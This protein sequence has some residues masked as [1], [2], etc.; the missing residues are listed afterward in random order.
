MGKSN[1][2][3]SKIKSEC[4]KAG[5][6]YS[7]PAPDFIGD[8]SPQNL[9]KPHIGTC[10]AICMLCGQPCNIYFSIRKTWKRNPSTKIKPS[11]K[12]YKRIK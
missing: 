4:C 8:S 2:K 5:V 7:E 1:K 11:K 3:K 12:I 10:Y 6:R 9:S